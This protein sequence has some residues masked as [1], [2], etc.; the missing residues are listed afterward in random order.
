MVGLLCTRFQS[1]V[2]AYHASSPFGWGVEATVDHYLF[3]KVMDELRTVSGEVVEAPALMTAELVLNWESAWQAQE[4][5]VVS[6]EAYCFVGHL[7]V[8]GCSALVERQ[9]GAL[10]RKFLAILRS[11]V[12]SWT[13][14]S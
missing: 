2:A 4:V 14:R 6:A 11:I 10:E 7:E 13:S 12:T 5:K 8:N 1:L 3:G 9:L